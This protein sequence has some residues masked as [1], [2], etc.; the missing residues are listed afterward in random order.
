M[1]FGSHTTVCV[2]SSKMFARTDLRLGVLRHRRANHNK[3]KLDSC[4]CEAMFINIHTWLCL[5]TF[6]NIHIS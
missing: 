3:L 4:F 2:H 5:T 1:L 6:V